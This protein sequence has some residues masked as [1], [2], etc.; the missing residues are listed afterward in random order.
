MQG[1]DGLWCFTS[2]VSDEGALPFD[3]DH[4]PEVKLVT[5]CDQKGLCLLHNLY[6]RLMQSHVHSHT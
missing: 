6:Y 4:A 3:G 5:T 1:L 2:K